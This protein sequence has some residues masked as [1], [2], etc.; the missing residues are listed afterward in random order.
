MRADGSA[1]DPDAFVEADL[2]LHQII[3]DAAHNQILARFMASLTR[4]GTA[5]RRRTGALPGVRTHS[6][7]D[8]Q[9]IVDA[10]L[11]R[12]SEAAAA[13]MRQHLENIQHSLRESFA[14]QSAEATTS[15]GKDVADHNMG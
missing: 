10:L 8:H 14:E 11:R 7:Q 4:L 15:G 13:M 1:D 3:T 9:A 6:L 5:S 2:E 12:D